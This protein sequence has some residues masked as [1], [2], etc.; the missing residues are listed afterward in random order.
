MVKLLCRP[1]QFRKLASVKRKYCNKYVL[2]VTM[3]VDV[4]RIKS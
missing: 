1:L 3:E 2:N 4:K